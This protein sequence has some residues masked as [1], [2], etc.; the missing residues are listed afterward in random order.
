MDCIL[1]RITD[2]PVDIRWQRVVSG[3]S[4]V[5]IRG[6][7]ATPS[8]PCNV[9]TLGWGRTDMGQLGVCFDQ[10]T[11]DSSMVASSNGKGIVSPF[12]LHEIPTFVQFSSHETSTLP[13]QPSSCSGKIIEVWCGSEY[14]LVCN[15]QREI[16]GAGWND[17]G[18][19]GCG[20]NSGSNDGCVYSWQPATRQT[21]TIT[22][23]VNK[24]EGSIPHTRNNVVLP[25]VYEGYLACGGSHCIA[26]SI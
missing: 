2:V 7:Q 18:N 14:T 15:E 1:R 9:C 16:Y 17:H 8:N 12:S 10:V 26:M 13:S 22:E 6:Y 24:L 21:S 11:D 4:H 3:W 20:E 19:L 5:C 23:N 25:S